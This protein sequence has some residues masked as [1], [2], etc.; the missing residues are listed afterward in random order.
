MESAYDVPRTE[1]LNKFMEKKSILKDVLETYFCQG[2]EMS[3]DELNQFLKNESFPDRARTFKRELADAIINH[4]ITPEEFQD[5][6]AVDQDSQEDVDKF[7]TTEI[8]DPLYDN[9]P[10]RMIY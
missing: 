4:K 9:E 5:L 1:A 3:Y 10:V 2:V 6:T 7:L 8:W